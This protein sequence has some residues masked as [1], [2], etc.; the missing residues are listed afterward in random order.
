[1][2]R[3]EYEALHAP[4][5]QHLLRELEFLAEELRQDWAPGLG[6]FLMDPQV[7]FTNNQGGQDIRMIEVKQ[8]ISGCFRPSRDPNSY[9]QQYIH[10]C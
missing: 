1:M 7:P 10:Y 3:T 9:A 6:T 4:C 5:N 8:K 2:D